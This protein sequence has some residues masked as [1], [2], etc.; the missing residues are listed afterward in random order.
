MGYACGYQ[1]T[2]ALFSIETYPFLRP[3]WGKFAVIFE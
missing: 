1:N 2:A 3:L